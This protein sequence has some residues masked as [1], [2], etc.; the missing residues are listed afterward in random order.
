MDKVR[1]RNSLKWRLLLYIPLPLLFAV[2]GSYLIGFGSNE[3]QAMYQKRFFK[4]NYEQLLNYT[5]NYTSQIEY[6]QN[7]EIKYILFQDDAGV[8]HIV[9]SEDDAIP[10]GTLEAIGY[11][12]VSDLQFIL[13]PLWVMICMIVGSF[14][15][16]KREIEQGLHILLNASEKIAGNELEFE[17]GKT[18]ENEIGLVCDSF[19]TMR[20]SLYEASV[21]NV[22]ILEES[23]RLNAAFSHDIRT[24]ITVMK[25]YIDFLEKYIPEGK[26]S[27]EKEYEI[28][29]MM[30]SQ[31]TR[32]ENYAVSMSSIQK[33]EDLVPEFLSVDY[34]QFVS[35][36]ESV[37][38]FIDG[39]VRLSYTGIVKDTVMI[40]KELVLEV[41][42]NIVSNAARYA[43]ETI[44]VEL[45]CKQDM[46]S[47]SVE[48]DGA[49]FSEN[50]LKLFGKPF[51]REEKEGDSSH[52]GL[53]IY[54]SKLLCEK[55]GGT[56]IIENREGAFVQATFR[57]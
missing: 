24:P 23:R 21:K 26:V 12:I 31:V 19:E 51:L 47:V 54:I 5:E 45:V 28:L 14:R 44:W 20:K 38:K 2:A 53:G 41:V 1:K 15:F 36:L 11:T 55:C 18:K 39:R 16:Y 29:Q 40:D 13:I 4:N 50:I 22:R 52:F 37:C 10:K 27:R 56:L 30:S 49:G 9:L 3:L 46:L 34:T 32:L 33:L 35:E 7:N 43:K 48:D 8:N 42:E 25:G 6:N 17:M 57:I